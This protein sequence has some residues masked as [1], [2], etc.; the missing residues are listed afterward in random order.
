MNRKGNSY[1]NACIES[2]HSIIKKEFIFHEDYRTREQTKANISGYIISF[3]N[4]KRIHGLNNYM[5][6][7]IY[8]QQY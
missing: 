1:D 2:F 8:E 7:T 3:Y 6:S 4:F 5:L